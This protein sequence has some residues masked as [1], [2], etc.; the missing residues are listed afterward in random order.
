[1]S[2]EGPG[3]SCPECGVSCGLA[4]LAEERR[5]RYLATMQFTTE[6]VARLPRSRCAEYSAKTIQPP[7]ARKHSRLTLLFEVFATELLQASRNVKAAAALLGL[8]RECVQR[9]MDRAVERGLDPH[10]A[11]PI[12]HVGINEKSLGRGQDYVTVLTD[13]PDG[14]RVLDVASERTQVAA[15]AVL[16][17]LSVEQRQEGRAVAAD[18]LPAY[19]KAVALQTPNAE[20]VHSAFHLAKHLGDAVDQARRNKITGLITS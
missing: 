16:Q 20:L 14:S 3:I 13:D 15:E 19:A 18:T 4:N 7:W 1:M 10:E 2:H 8:I 17:T 5:W 9:I 11:T 6:L 12:K